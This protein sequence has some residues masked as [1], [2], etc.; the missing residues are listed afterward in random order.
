M[1]KKFN[2]VVIFLLSLSL[3]SLEMVWTRIFS[4]EFFYTFAFLILS[5]AILGLGVGAL[6]LRLF[7][8]LNRE[9]TPGAAI[10]L[11]GFMAIAGPPLV[12]MLN[13][14][15]TE[16]LSGWDMILK[17]IITIFILS[18][19][20][21]FGGIALAYL[22]KRNSRRIPHLYMA[23]LVGS[24]LGVV[25][26][27]VLMN[28]FS[29]PPAA[30]LIAIPAL[31]AALIISKRQMKL[32]PI[33]LMI[34]AFAMT[35]QSDSLLE[36]RRSESAPVIYQQWDAVSKI[37]VYEYDTNYR[38]INI[39]NIANSPVYGFD[40]NWKKPDSLKFRFG[41]DVKYLINKF[42][43]CTFLSL[44]SGGGTDVLQ[45]LQYGCEEVHAVEVIPHINEIMLEG[46]LADFSGNIYKDPRVKVATED[47]RVYVRQ[48]RDKFDVIYALSANSW[49]AMA[50]GAFALAENYLFTVEAFE[51]YWRALSPKGYM[52]MEHQF[53]V[54]R[55]V[56]ELKMAL[57][58]LNVKNPDKHFAVYNLPQ[59]RRNILL[60]SKQPLDKETLH[61]AFGRFPRNYPN[62]N[63]LLYP[64]PDS[65]SRNM[66]ADIVDRGWRAVQDSAK[67]DISPATDNRPF[68]AQ[69]GMWKNFRIDTSGRIPPYEFTG[70]PISKIIMIII[71]GVIVLIVIPLNLLPYMRKTT[72]K[73]KLVPWLYFFAIGMAFMAIEIIL[74]QKYALFIGS[75]IYSIAT[76]LITLLVASG[77][78][79]RLTEKFRNYQPFMFIIIWVLLDIFA[80][81]NVI[82]AVEG[83]SLAMRIGLTALWIAPL[84]F[85]M[86]M[87]FPKAGLRVGELIDWGFAVNGAASVLGSVIIVLVAI[88]YGFA[89]SLGLGA[90]MY[91]VALLLFRMSK[92]W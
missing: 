22:F 42:D 62:F 2:Y 87:P 51:D 41:I 17:L 27:I 86:G 45:A 78:G 72:R 6:S 84:G 14:E 71:L 40:G 81:T 50:S 67:I 80:F 63:Y 59:M 12:F 92:S 57:N 82:Y 35:G 31:I 89:V 49:A 13:L 74:M 26:A 70:F 1:M 9:E 34:L 65:A 75:S 48:F 52:M 60:I 37:K 90:A 46:D 43:D 39:D 64:L 24:G 77:I 36:A 44:G 16:L 68:V 10:S 85:F 18:S 88:E 56:T 76:V 58:N 7:P 79:S 83:V 66:I 19:S 3:I 38:G 54:P 5:L 91:L 23:D 4:A 33:A 55:L 61:N 20:F 28:A 29:T 15:F 25:M 32:V 73:L 21:F 53:Y 8:G 11:S 30:Q 69:L 47:G